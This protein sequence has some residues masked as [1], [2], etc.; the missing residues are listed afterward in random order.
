MDVGRAGVEQRLQLRGDRGLV[1]DDRRVG[2]RCGAAQFD[3][4]LE[5][6]PAGVQRRGLGLRVS[7]F[8]DVVVDGDGQTGDDSRRRP[9]GAAA[10]ALISGATC[11]PITCGVAS[12]ST[13]PSATSPAT[14]SSRGPSADTRT[15]TG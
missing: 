15:G 3:D 7:R 13:V 2:G 8:V 4:A 10:A 6:R 12:Q 1:A 5:V 11:S 9:T 14:R